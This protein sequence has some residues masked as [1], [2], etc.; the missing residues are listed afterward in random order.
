MGRDQ[1]LKIFISRFYN[2]EYY[3]THKVSPFLLDYED[4]REIKDQI[5]LDV[6]DFCLKTDV[7]KTLNMSL[8]DL[9]ELDLPTYVT[10]KDAVRKENEKKAK[11]IDEQQKDLDKRQQ[12]LLG[13]VT[14]A[15]RRRQ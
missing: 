15:Y 9:M 5:L 3:S 7:C 4:N 12:K 14:N 10:I 13:G 2:K 6:L 1:L 8:K 11:V